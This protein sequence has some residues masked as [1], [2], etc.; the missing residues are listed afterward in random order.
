V[1][2]VRIRAA[3]LHQINARTTSSAGALRAADRLQP[4]MRMNADRK[5]DAITHIAV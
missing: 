1:R 5:I 4:A 2:I 3:S